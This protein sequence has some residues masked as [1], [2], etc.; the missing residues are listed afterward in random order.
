[1]LINDTDA[2]PFEFPAH[3]KILSPSTFPKVCNGLPT[4]ATQTANSA[5]ERAFYRVLYPATFR[6][7]I[8]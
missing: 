5:C 2:F 7:A 6:H 1:M 3:F 4:K 8:K